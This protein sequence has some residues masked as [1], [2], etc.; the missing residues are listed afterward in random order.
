MY[1]AKHAMLYK[2]HVPDGQAYIFYIDIRSGGKGYEEFVHRA[3][4][5]DDIMYLRG[6][7]S[8]LYKDGNKIKVKGVDTLSGQLVEID[9]DMVVLALAMVPSKGTAEIAKTL[10]IGVDKDGFLA[11]GHAKLKPVESVT[12][13]IYLAG[14]A[15]SP[16]D[17]PETV[18]QASAAAAKVIGL[19]SKDTLSHAPTVARVIENLCTGCDMCVQACPYDAVKVSEA[20]KA[21]VNEVLCV[22]CGACSATC[23][24][25]AIEVKNVTPLQVHEMINACLGG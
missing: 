5:D 18:T 17:I 6:K 4:E 10:K 15:Q 8:R 12:A 11:E 21:Q 19:L 24:R 2:H 23:L 1:T 16:K 22:G 20:G 25:A 14:A 7:V 3:V 13:G 9:A